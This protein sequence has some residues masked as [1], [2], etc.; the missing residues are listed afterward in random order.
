MCC[1]DSKRPLISRDASFSQASLW[2]TSS[3]GVLESVSEYMSEVK[4]A[5]N[6][7]QLVMVALT[8]A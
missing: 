5:G 1:R 8:P 4:L 3:Q 2:L 6:S 7:R